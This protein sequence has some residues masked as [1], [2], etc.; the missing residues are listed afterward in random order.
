[1]LPDV[2]P[3]SVIDDDGGSVM[4]MA[5]AVMMVVEARND[6]P[7]GSKEMMPAKVMMVMWPAV[8]MLH[9]H[10]LTFCRNRRG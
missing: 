5:V 6:L 2:V 9:L 3:V 8:M 4:V 10:Y 1:M 7:G